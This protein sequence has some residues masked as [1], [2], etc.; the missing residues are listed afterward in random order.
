MGTVKPPAPGMHTTMTSGCL[1][2]YLG[3]S[4]PFFC[5]WPCSPT[6]CQGF[7]TDLLAPV[8]CGEHRRSGLS[9][10]GSVQWGRAGALPGPRGLSQLQVPLPTHLPGPSWFRGPLWVASVCSLPLAC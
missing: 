9:A 8:T 3:V 1:C 6:S 4:G 7:S 10:Q 2:S 5:L